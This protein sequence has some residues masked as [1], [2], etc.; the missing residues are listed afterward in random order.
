M[1]IY[2]GTR[3]QRHVLKV[4]RDDLDAL[5][6]TLPVPMSLSFD[7]RLDHLEED[8]LGEHNIVEG[9][10]V[11]RLKATLVDGTLYAVALHEVGHAWGLG[12]SKAGIMAANDD[13]SDVRTLSLRNRRKWLG[14]VGR[15]VVAKRLKELVHE[16]I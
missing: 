2:G 8:D 5:G 3:A 1:R 10:H 15:A 16:P 11:I 7:S 12:H 6:L 13:Y 9:V 14:Q 4:L